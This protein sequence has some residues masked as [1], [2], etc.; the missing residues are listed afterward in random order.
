MP[1]NVLPN[2]GPEIGGG[3][4]DV[5]FVGRVVSSEDAI[6]GLTHSFFSVPCG[7]VE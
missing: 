6:V 4:F 5:G 7:E 1:L 2:F 3:D